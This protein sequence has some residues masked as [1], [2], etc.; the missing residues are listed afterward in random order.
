MEPVSVILLILV[1]TA[2]FIA[3]YVLIKS[4]KP[5]F[6]EKDIKFIRNKWNKIESMV[7]TGPNEAVL[8]ADKLLG[9]VLSKK[10]YE[11]SVGGQLKK[12]DA[13][14][15]NPNNIWNAHKLRNKI[16]HEMDFKVSDKEIKRAI[17]QFKSALNELGIKI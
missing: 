3:A 11:G 12:A 7:K 8:E 4:Q 1:L 9:Y 10:G 14:F 2:V 16:A 17:N 6:S 5:K 13:E 15:K